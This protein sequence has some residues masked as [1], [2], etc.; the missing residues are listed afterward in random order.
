MLAVE[1]PDV[2]DDDVLDEAL[3]AG[4]LAQGS[5]GL[6]VS[7]VA[8]HGVN[9]DVAGVRLGREAVVADVNPGALHADVL[10]IEGVE[11]VGV[12]RKSSGVVGL[13]GDN[14]VLEGDVLGWGEC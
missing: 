5:H 2:L 8:V 12:L 6:A 13:G 10:D 3:L 11:E 7:T 1:H 14:D 9:V 4:V